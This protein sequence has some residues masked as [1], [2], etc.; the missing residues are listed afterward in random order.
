[1]T[2]LQLDS[3]TTT[4]I[5][6]LL[7]YYTVWKK[8]SLNALQISFVN[9][10]TNVLFIIG[11]AL[12]LTMSFVFLFLI[13]SQVQ[14]FAQ[15]TTDQMIVFFITYQII[16]QITQVFYR[17]VYSFGHKIRN[18][19]F[20]FYLVRPLNALF[21]TLF[22]QPDINDVLFLLP[23][24]AVMGYLF[25]TLNLSITWLSVGWYLLLL[26]N[27]FLIATAFHI[28]VA[29]IAILTTE[30]DGII[31]MY[32]DLSAMGRFP[33]SIYL[34]PLRFALFFIVPVGMMVTIPAELLVGAPPTHS[35]VLAILVGVVFLATSLW[36]WREALKQYSSASS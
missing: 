7:T 12:R 20:D 1:M 27:S 31:W 17:S 10:Y 22:G 15:Y 19:E 36:I 4:K 6:H 13:R 24:F 14:H 23:S 11:K 16:D 18:G 32:R 29:A 33:V 9:R 5:M 30:V 28:I 25:S 21:P 34:E 3:N 26:M 8:L 2:T 35:I